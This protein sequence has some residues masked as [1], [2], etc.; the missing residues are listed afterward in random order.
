M[1]HQQSTINCKGRLLDLTQPIVMGILNMTP[2]SFYDGGQYNRIDS[3]L[4][5]AEKMIN[6]GAD[7]LDVGGMSSR[8]GAEVISEEEEIRRV[9]PVIKKLNEE[10]PET[11]L[12]IDTVHA[13][14]LRE[15][16]A[17]GASMANDISAGSLDPKYFSMLAEMKIPYILM[18]M[19]GRPENMQDQP[20]Y[21]DI[22]TEILDFFIEKVGFLRELGVVDIILD[23]GFG[24]GKTVE[25]NYEL[26]NKMHV[27]KI[28]GLPLMA[29]IS[30]KSMIYKVLKNSANEALNGSTALHMVALQQGA[31][32]LRVHDVKE[33]R[34]TIS[35]FQQLTN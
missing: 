13:S 24:F 3:A 12:S 2:D 8:P 26:L 32:I 10:F 21:D 28:L 14:V 9:F 1:L 29:G 17:A 11:I 22:A 5:L 35:L 18:H 16:V 25:Q 31:K 34:E 30:R 20:E 15:A 27:F 33:A 6:Q 19:K 7:V 23:P 4:H